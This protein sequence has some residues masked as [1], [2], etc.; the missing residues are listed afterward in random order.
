MNEKE[1]GNYKDT[2]IRKLAE[3]SGVAEDTLISMSKSGTTFPDPL[4]RALSESNRSLELRK[5]DRERKLIK[6]IR[7]AIIKIDDGSYGICE[8]CGE[9]ISANRLKVRPEAAMCISCKEEEE[10][11]EKKFGMN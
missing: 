8:N 9:Y 10:E 7:D 2:L 3:L 4:D 5:R 11:F 6:K 1:L